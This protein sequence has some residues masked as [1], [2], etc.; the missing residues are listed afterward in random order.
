MY[1]EGSAR[2]VRLRSED[3]ERAREQALSYAEIGDVEGL[4]QLVESGLDLNLCRGLLGYTCLHHACNRGRVDVVHALL[5][6]N[7]NVNAKNDADETPLHLACYNGRLLVV[8]LLIDE[9]ADIN[10]VNQYGETPLIYA[11]K[12]DMPAIVRLLLQRGCNAALKD[13]FGDT[14]LDHAISQRT[15]D[16]L[17]QQHG[18]NS[19]WRFSF[20]S[21]IHVFRYLELKD[22]CRCA[23]VNGSWHRAAENEGLWGALG[24]RRWELALQST[25]GFYEAPSVSFSRKSRSRSVKNIT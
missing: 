7:V 4:K 16:E 15:K 2:L 19:G 1:G 14:A 12:R 10:A 5:R 6:Y 8:E 13:R 25:L 3:C 20:D 11:S 23:R 9:Q 22:L 17:T 18:V 21:L 24:V